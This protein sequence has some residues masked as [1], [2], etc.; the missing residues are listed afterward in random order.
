MSV[1]QLCRCGHAEGWHRYGYVDEGHERPVLRDWTPC[2]AQRCTCTGFRAA[3]V[4]APDA[5]GSRAE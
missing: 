1:E 2:Q 3:A 4:Q 5:I